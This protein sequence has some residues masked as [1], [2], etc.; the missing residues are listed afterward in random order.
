MAFWWSQR[1]RVVESEMFPSSYWIFAFYI[2]TAVGE[3]LLSL[4]KKKKKNVFT[5]IYHIFL[6]ICVHGVVPQRIWPTL[7][8]EPSTVQTGPVFLQPGHC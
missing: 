7:P 1:T 2:D 3:H 8:E 6:S 5:L 4:K